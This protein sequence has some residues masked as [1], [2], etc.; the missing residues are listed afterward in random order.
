MAPSATASEPGRDL[1]AGRHDHV[2][3]ARVVQRREFA[4]PAD[5]LVG[6]PGHGRDHDGDLIAAVDL[7]LH[8]RR[9]M[10]DAV[11]VGHRGAAEFHY[12]LG[13]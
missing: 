2:V 13:H 9:H 10:A 6:L 7:G 4:G 3:F 8:Q 1:L 12:N 11:E 5:E